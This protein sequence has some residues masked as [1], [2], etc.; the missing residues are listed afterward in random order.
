MTAELPISPVILRLGMTYDRSAVHITS[1][2]QVQNER[3]LVS[4]PYPQ[5]HLGSEWNITS[6][7]FISQ[8]IPRLGMKYD[9]WAIRQIQD[10]NVGCSD[11]IIY[12]IYIFLLTYKYIYIYSC[13]HTNTYTYIHIHIIY[14]ERERYPCRY[15]R[16]YSQLYICM[17]ICVHMYI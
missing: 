14:I 1:H 13:L 3:R 8:V 9:R 5:S 6:E 11:W 15:I 12:C 2:T 17:Y 7:L 4:C 16:M 10:S